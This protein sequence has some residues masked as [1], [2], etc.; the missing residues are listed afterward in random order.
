V[1]FEIQIIR[2]RRSDERP[3]VIDRLTHDAPDLEAAKK[4]AKDLVM[5]VSWRSQGGGVSH[6]QPRWPC[7]RHV[8]RGGRRCLNGLEG[9]T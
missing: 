7:A 5:T 1:R 3:E 9:L 2:F 6:P 8:A 4:K